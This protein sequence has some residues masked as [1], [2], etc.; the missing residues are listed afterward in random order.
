[1]KTRRLA[2]IALVATT[3]LGT[4]G[5]TFITP[6]ATDIQY[7]PADGVSADF[8]PL[9]VR[10]AL[11]IADQDGD[12]G[13]LVAAIANNSAD[14][15]TVTIEYGPQDAGNRETVRVPANSVLTLGHD[16][17]DALLLADLGTK[18]GEMVSV[19]F[20]GADE[21]AVTLVPVFDGEHPY[22]GDLV[23]EA[24]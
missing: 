3:M 1:M 10:D 8:G 13:N 2:T 17:E 15:Q 6:Q 5:C 9:K 19:Y 21:S 16:G 20:S 23:P 24:D 7:N 12:S 18:P 4:A 22:L 14:S 11:V